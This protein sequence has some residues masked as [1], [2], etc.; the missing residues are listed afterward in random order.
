MCQKS[1]LSDEIIGRYIV[2]I[3]KKKTSE[4]ILFLM[5]Y[6]RRFVFFFQSFNHFLKVPEVWH[7]MAFCSLSYFC[8][9]IS[10]AVF[11]F[12]KI[13]L[14]RIYN[15][16]LQDNISILSC[17]TC[18]NNTVCIFRSLIIR[19]AFHKFNWRAWFLLI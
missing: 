15:T 8:Q 2:S 9:Y 4:E 19:K 13:T 12:L 1:I 10:T 17:F 5:L 18:C 14:I 7:I 6:L 3:I 11:N 16:L